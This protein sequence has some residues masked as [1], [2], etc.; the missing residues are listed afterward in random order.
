M[1]RSVFVYG[2]MASGKTANAEALRQHFGLDTILDDWQYGDR[3]PSRGALILTREDP[4]ELLGSH[5]PEQVYSIGDALDIV[6]AARVIERGV[7]QARRTS[8]Q[9][10][11]AHQPCAV[12]IL[13]SAGDAIADRAAARDCP[14]GERS[15]AR[16][17]RAFNA[18]TGHALTE[19]EGWHFMELLKLARA[20]AG[21]HHID[22]H[23]DRA[24]YAGLAG[25]AAAREALRA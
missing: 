2:P 24:A 18:I 15:M 9:P 14:N 4:R 19:V 25:E 23:V 8:D 17:V 3:W 10:V 22:D 11:Q 16:C 12:S 7:G 6:G 1:K 21:A 5:A 20:T 13:R